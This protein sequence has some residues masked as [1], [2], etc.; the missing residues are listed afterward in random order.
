V[1]TSSVS[2]AS[3]SKIQEVDVEINQPTW[4]QIQHVEVNIKPASWYQIQVVEVELK[5]GQWVLVQTVEVEL[6]KGQWVLVQTVEVVIE[7]ELEQ[8]QWV[9]VQTVEVRIGQAKWYPIQIIDVNIVSPSGPLVWT[10]AGDDN[11]ASN[12]QNWNYGV[13]PYNG[14]DV[15]FDG[16][17]VKDCIWDLPSW[18]VTVNSLT[19]ATG[20]IGTLTQ[21]NVD[22]GIGE[23]G[24]LQHGGTF[25]G[26]ER[27]IYC[28]G[29]FRYVAG[30]CRDYNL[31]MMG[32]GHDLMVEANTFVRSIRISGDTV[33]SY[34]GSAPASI[35]SLTVENGTRLTIAAG[36]ALV[37]YYW[38]TPAPSY[39]N[40]GIIGGDGELR[41][42]MRNA[43]GEY[44]LGVVECPVHIYSHESSSGSR[45]I[46]MTGP[47]ILTSSLRISSYHSTYTMTLDLNGH[48]LIANGI[49]VG[50]GGAIVGDGKIENAGDLET[51]AGFFDY[52]GMYI[53]AG[54]GKIILAH[55]QKLN[56][57]TVY[58]PVRL[59]LGNDLTVQGE[60]IGIKN[61][62][63]NGYRI[64][65]NGVTHL[66]EYPSEFYVSEPVYI[67]I[68]T[69]VREAL[70]VY[71]DIPRWMKYDSQKG[72]LYGVPVGV[73]LHDFNISC[74][75]EYT[76][77]V[78]LRVSFAV[79]EQTIQKDDFRGQSIGSIISIILSIIVIGMCGI[80][81]GP[82]GKMDY[83]ISNVL[84]GGAV[85]V[86]VL[87]FASVIPSYGLVI[88]AFLLFALYW[89][90]RR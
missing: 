20:Y 55:G 74:Y 23:G 48:S 39:T 32:D 8:A 13:T 79:L 25:L 43:D 15:V 66:G 90:G 57:L 85:V 12:P 9:L 73:G 78:T 81:R 19:L 30:S 75:S 88:V 69:P 1:L 49:T 36:K 26:S 51:S 54:N 59:T 45:T 2:A 65:I 22:M 53:Q 44:S 42:Q 67:P 63:L 60:L 71:G 10:G 21:G 56:D 6:E 62:I 4:I 35:R 89:G 27:T 5:Q 72:G 84:L 29:S 61:I 82:D 18:Q 83:Q 7:V 16:T 52:T 24:Y 38:T 77:L 58:A 68:K 76:D 47:A 33:Y 3:W 86:S 11:L 64:Y 37:I 34:V 70:Y 41:F 40:Y 14:A 46:K 87:V 17:S 28:D 31:V 80:T 50:A